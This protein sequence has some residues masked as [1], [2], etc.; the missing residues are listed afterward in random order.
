MSAADEVVA[1]KFPADNLTDKRSFIPKYGADLVGAPALN[2]S[3]YAAPT[4]AAIGVIVTG[5]AP[6]LGLGD[7]PKFSAL[8]EELPKVLLALGFMLVVATAV[9][10]V[11]LAYAADMKAR[12]LVTAASLRLREQ[13]PLT[14]VPPAASGAPGESA[15]L[16][17]KR[18]TKG[19]DE[20]L[21]IAGNK[22]AAG[23]TEYLLT[24]DDDTPEWIG[25]ADISAWEVKAVS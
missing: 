10:S 17:V 20:F 6:L 5:V 25:E 24:K 13:V 7:F 18:K 22:T 4:V 8:T 12:G 23:L 1:S 21:V 19:E 11:S 14:L 9:L 2:L 15:G 3:K 16:W